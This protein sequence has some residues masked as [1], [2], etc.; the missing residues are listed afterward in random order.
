LKSTKQNAQLTVAAGSAF[1]T[2]FFAS[3]A[4]AMAERSGKKISAKDERGVLG[5]L[6]STR[7]GRLGRERPQPP[8]PPP[9][10]PP[11]R[12]S[13]PE[14]VTGAVRAAGGVAQAGLAVG[15]HVVKRAAARL[16]VW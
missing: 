1:P 12:S 7:P 9:P 14:L 8:P 4:N 13:G 16:R 6:S 2:R 3:G 5:S 11:E 15:T 10:P